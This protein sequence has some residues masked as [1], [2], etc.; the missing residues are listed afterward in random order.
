M[1]KT[2]ENLAIALDLIKTEGWAVANLQDKESGGYCLL[3]AI[4]AARTGKRDLENFTE[5][6]Y[7]DSPEVDAV[8]VVLRNIGQVNEDRLNR[9]REDGELY[10]LVYGFNDMTGR[11]IEEVIDVLSKA[12]EAAGQA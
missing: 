5:D 4:Y 1:N 12:I 10:A 2:R 9:F 7:Q 6:G 3:G 11:R 8:A